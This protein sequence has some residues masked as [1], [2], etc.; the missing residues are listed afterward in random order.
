MYFKEQRFQKAKASTLASTHTVE[1]PDSGIL[2]AIAL[3]FGAVNTSIVYQDQPSTIHGHITKIEVVG[4]TDKTL[5]SMTGQC[6][7][8]K[9]FRKMRSMPPMTQHG[10]GAK[11]Q[12]QLIPIFFGRKP[13]D[14]KYALDLSQ[15]DKVELKVTNN[16]SASY[17]TSL[18]MET[19]LHTIEDSV[20]AHP[21]FLKQWEYEAAKPDAAGDYYRPKLP[22]K[23]LLRTLMVQLDPDLTASTGAVAADP[24]G[25]SYNWKLWFKDRA[26]TIFDHRP[27]DLMR[28]EHFARNLGIGVS[29]GHY[30]PSTSQYMDF[31]WAYIESIA[32]GHI[33]TGAADVT[34]NLLDDSQSRYQVLNFAGAAPFYS[35]INRGYGL[36][37]TFEIPW[38]VDDEET[39][40]LNL[41]QYKPIE[42][43]WYG[44]NYY[45]T[46]RMILEKP[47]GQGANEYA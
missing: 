22:T 28:D 19:R 11:T 35:T 26:L 10:Y 1:L 44:Y 6:A 43:E 29:S 32:M 23:G 36:F 21:K 27:K 42:I 39:E 7:I 25:D 34:R 37:H 15:W 38:F 33:G 17:F 4:D 24:I 47:I 30:Y 40:Y 3:Q 31:H 16:M 46:H 8:A 14:G 5:F 9:A 13:H 12:W 20:E 41:E 18:S 2:D 45:N